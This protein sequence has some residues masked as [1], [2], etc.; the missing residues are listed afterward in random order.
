MNNENRL[1]E[2]RQAL[3]TEKCNETYFLSQLELALREKKYRALSEYANK[4]E[5]C[6]SQQD[7]LEVEIRSIETDIEFEAREI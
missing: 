1:S 5:S 3:N 7:W 4:L 2:A 6:K